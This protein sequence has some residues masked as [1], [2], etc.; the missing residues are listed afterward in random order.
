MYAQPNATGTLTAFAR[1]MADPPREPGDERPAAG[2]F[3][4]P[5]LVAPG[6]RD[7]TSHVDFTTL[8]REA[9]RAGWSTRSVSSQ[10]RFLLDLVERSGLVNELE[11]P[12]RLRDRLALKSLLVPGAFG[13]SH[14]VLVFA[15][16]IEQVE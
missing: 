4:P 6:T 5:W 11:R 8:Q 10:S 3:T 2:R 12:D 15:R 1:H 9:G 13:S 16:N 7:L 14:S